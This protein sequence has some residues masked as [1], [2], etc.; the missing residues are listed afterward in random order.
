MCD[1]I[2]IWLDQHKTRLISLGWF[3]FIIVIFG[4]LGPT[5]AILHSLWQGNGAAASIS[6]QAASGNFIVFSTAML[7]SSSYFMVREYIKRKEIGNRELK[8]SLLLVTAITILLGVFIA[9]ELTQNPAFA[10]R[11]NAIFHWSIYTFSILLSTILWTV[12]ENESASAVVKTWENN[13]KRMTSESEK[14]TSTING[15]KI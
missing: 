7:A 9:F 1:P 3:I 13:A 14:N 10:Y 8:S 12:E 2:K 5:L 11:E 4:Q 6:T 15:M